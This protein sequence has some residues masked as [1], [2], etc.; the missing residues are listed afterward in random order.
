MDPAIIAL[1]EMDEDLNLF[2]TN[3][4]FLCLKELK[5]EYD[6]ADLKKLIE[7]EKDDI[8]YVGNYYLFNFL[9]SGLT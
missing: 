3:I 2:D 9:E 4:Y 6:I 8:D 1:K 5:R 7:K